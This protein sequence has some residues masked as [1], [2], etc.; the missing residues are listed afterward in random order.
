MSYAETEYTYGFSVKNNS[1]ESAFRIFVGVELTEIRPAKAIKKTRTKAQKSGFRGCR[2]TTAVL[3]ILIDAERPSF[4]SK[5]V[6]D[7]Q[8]ERFPKRYSCAK[9]KNWCFLGYFCRLHIFSSSKMAPQK[10]QFSHF[11]REYLFGNL[12]D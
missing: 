6:L 3:S 12:S 4:Y 9:C 7:F 1:L 10:H 8:S 11:A 2:Y 5:V